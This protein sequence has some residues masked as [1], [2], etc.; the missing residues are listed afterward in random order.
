MRL[1]LVVP[2]ILKLHSSGVEGIFEYV[3]DVF[4]INGTCNLGKRFGIEI[5]CNFLLG[6]LAAR[7]L[8][9]QSVFMCPRNK[10]RIAPFFGS[11]QL[12]DLFDLWS[13]IW[14]EGL[15]IGSIIQIP[16]WREIEAATLSA[17]LH[18]SIPDFLADHTRIVR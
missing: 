10:A 9:G 14:I 18:M 2:A 16:D 4:S 3:L 15:I 1:A 17:K 12:K 8:L 5:V 7:W 11:V 6:S 13:T